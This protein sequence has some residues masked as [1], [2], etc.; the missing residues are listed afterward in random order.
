[1]PR[2]AA[3][4]VATSGEW[5]ETADGFAPLRNVDAA[6]LRDLVAAEL[7]AHAATGAIPLHL[8]RQRRRACRRR[9]RDIV[10]ADYHAD[11]ARRCAA[12]QVRDRCRRSAAPCRTWSTRCAI[13]ISV[14]LAAASTRCCSRSA[15]RCVRIDPARLGDEL[16]DAFEQA[17]S[18]LSLS[19]IIPAADIAELDD[20]WQS[21]ID[22]LRA[23]DPGDLV[24][25]ALQPIWDE[26][27]LAAA[28][29]VRSDAGLRRA[30]RIPR[31][32]QG[33]TERRSRSS[34]HRV[35]VAHRPAPRAAARR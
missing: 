22:K 28:R 6:T 33:R 19:T 16:D 5:T 25:D 9:R 13:S 30:D 17:L 18:V 21:V 14:S 20:A 3:A 7:D 31:V 11:L 23:L 24:E 10:A 4:L 2:R 27:V 1:M 35:P 8:A 32:A 26:T 12:S 29:R 34:E 15:T